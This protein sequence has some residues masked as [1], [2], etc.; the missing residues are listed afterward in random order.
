MQAKK[1]DR[2]GRLYE[3]YDGRKAFPKSKSNSFELRDTDIEGKYWGRDRFDLCFHCMKE[4]EA[5][6]YGG[7]DNG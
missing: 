7:A 1:C 6:L 2:C 3:H 5:F 4:L